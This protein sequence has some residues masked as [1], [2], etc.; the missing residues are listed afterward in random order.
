MVFTLFWNVTPTFLCLTFLFLLETKV[1]EYFV[2][3]SHSL[4]QKKKPPLIIFIVLLWSFSATS[5]LNLFL[6][7]LQANSLQRLNSRFSC[8]LTLVGTSHSNINTY[9]RYVRYIPVFDSLR[10]W[11]LWEH[12]YPQ[13]CTHPPDSNLGPGKGTSHWFQ[14]W[15][16]LGQVASP[17]PLQNAFELQLLG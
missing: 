8:L 5:N 12:S 1:V 17:T 9:G 2:P 15:A 6:L 7:W 14:C 3:D 4:K 16:C 11:Q 10:L 13:L